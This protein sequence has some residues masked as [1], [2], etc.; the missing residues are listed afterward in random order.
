MVVNLT[1]VLDLFIIFNRLGFLGLSEAAANIAYGGYKG[2][3]QTLFNLPPSIISSINV[4]IIPAISA[5][6]IIGDR[7][8]VQH[9]AGRA[10]KLVLLLAVPCAVGLF[11][12]AD[13]IQR[14]LF[15]TRLS[16]IAV[17]TPLLKILESPRCLPVLRA[18]P[19]LSPGGGQHAPAGAVA[20]RGRACKAGC[21][22]YTGGTPGIGKLA[23]L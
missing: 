19:L 18:S 11:V 4:T 22:L 6:V 23:H 16:E 12:L 15:P 17:T 5:A 7:R 13:P 8:R 1:G 2:Y 14:M 20:Y 10:V 3:A 9:V 21:K